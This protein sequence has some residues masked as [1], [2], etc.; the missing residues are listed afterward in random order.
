MKR[1]AMK[2][3]GF[4]LSAMDCNKSRTAWNG[5]VLR[6]DLLEEFAFELN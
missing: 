6:T 1:K 4:V 2:E 5:L 3:F